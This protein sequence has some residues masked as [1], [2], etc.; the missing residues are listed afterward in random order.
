VRN[1]ITKKIRQIYENVV[2]LHSVSQYLHYG[3]TTS[4][5]CSHCIGP[6]HRRVIRASY[7]R[8]S[9][10]SD[11]L[12]TSERSIQAKMASHHRTRPTKIQYQCKFNVSACAGP[13]KMALSR[14]DCLAQCSICCGW[15]V[16]DCYG[17]IAIVVITKWKNGNKWSLSL[18]SMKVT[19]PD[20]DDDTRSAAVAERLCDA[21]YCLETYRPRCFTHK[22]SPTVA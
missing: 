11:W 4:T 9:T 19:L 16:V 1:K 22:M 2:K 17:F 18:C 12:A 21:P 5:I 10:I 6:I 15:F 8:P 20:D 13:F 14:R 7:E 3:E